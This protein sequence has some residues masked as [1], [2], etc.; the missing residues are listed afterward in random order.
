MAGLASVIEE[1]IR[2]P[3]FAFINVESPCVT[4]GED[5]H[6]LKDHRASMISLESLGHD[7]KDRLR[8]MD[9]A[10]EYGTKL[11]TGVFYRNP[12]P[13]PTFESLVRERQAALSEGAAP[14]ERI[15]ELFVQR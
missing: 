12:D 14:R 13:P 4:Y 9:L 7:P 2:Y 10:Q 8:A 5:D 11:Y 15:L 3:G 6:Q 1:G